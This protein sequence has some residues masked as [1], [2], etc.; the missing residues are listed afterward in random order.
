M[1]VN[2]R[3]DSQSRLSGLE[4]LF[5]HRVLKIMLRVDL[6]T[7]YTVEVRACPILTSPLG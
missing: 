2:R 6:V 4:P 3:G 5:T 7:P 1:K